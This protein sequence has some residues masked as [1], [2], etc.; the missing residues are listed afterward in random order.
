MA[1]LVRQIKLGDITFGVPADTAA[2]HRP[3]GFYEFMGVSKD[4]VKDQIE[5]AYRRLAFKLHPDKH[6][7]DRVPF[8]ELERVVEV[9][10]DDGGELGPKHSKRR[11]YDNVSAL[12]ERLSGQLEYHGERTRRFSEDV[13]IQMEFA[14]RQAKAMHD[15]RQEF[16][17]A[18][19]LEEE[20]EKTRDPQRRK[21]IVDSINELMAKKA[22]ISP[23][24]RVEIDARQKEEEERFHARQRELARTTNPKRFQVVDMY[25]HGEGVVTFGTDSFRRKISVLGL[26]P[27]EYI[28]RLD[29][30]GSSYVVGI[31]QVHF[32]SI[33]A[34]VDIRDPH[35]TGI[36]HTQQGDVTIVYES[37]TYGEVMRVRGKSVVHVGGFAQKGDLFVP[38]RFAT[39]N[40]WR[41]TPVLDVA[42]VDGSVR[43][44]LRSPVIRGYGK[45]VGGLESIIS[46]NMYNPI[47][48]K[49][50][51]LY[52]R[53][54]KY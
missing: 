47:D 48:T 25:H 20:F 37:S 39:Q 22:G 17:Q 34:D 42:T 30:V 2:L 40:W 26:D 24:Q 36:V 13:L 5:A 7:E 10:L 54:E 8:Q 3:W 49:I 23:E 33:Q 41:K 43:V 21:E 31:P 32:K 29:M 38:E 44:E 15:L 51:S 12:D 11:H 19:A 35:L 4:A 6:G 46:N 52:F 50:D 28:L 16:P 18:A 53:R 14:Q 45:I 1:D 9:L 27:R